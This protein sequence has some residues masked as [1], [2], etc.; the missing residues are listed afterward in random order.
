MCVFLR[1]ITKV[2]DRFLEQQTKIKFGVK[3]ENNSIDTSAK[4]SEAYRGEALKM[5]SIFEWY[6]PFKESSH[7][8]IT[9]DNHT[10]HFLRYQGYR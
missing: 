7:I 5:S 4:P 1:L 9:N 6:V 10:H 2:S 8:E 3:L